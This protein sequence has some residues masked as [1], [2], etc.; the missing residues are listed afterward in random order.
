M[1][2]SWIKRVALAVAVLAVLS[3]GGTWLYINVI[4]DDAPDRLTLQS[5]AQT[6]AV[7]RPGRRRDVGRGHLEG[8]DGQPGR[9]RSRCGDN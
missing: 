9:Y 1:T 4:T 2:G 7:G 5:P 6:A 8:D 3:V